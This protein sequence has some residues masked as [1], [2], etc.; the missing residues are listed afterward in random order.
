MRSRQTSRPQPNEAVGAP[1]YAKVGDYL[2]VL[3]AELAGA[4]PSRLP[5]EAALAQRFG[6]GRQTVRRAYGDLVAEGLVKRA[7]GRGS[8]PTRTHR[9]LGS[10][11]SVDDLLTLAHDRLLETVAPLTLI[12][13]SRA[14]MRL[15]L[16]SDD[17]G[18]VAYRL[19]YEG[20][21]Y[22]LT[23]IYLAPFA[24]EALADVIFLRE[25]GASGSETVV[26]LLNQRLEHPI[27]MARQTILAV[28]APPDVAAILGCESKRPLL[29]I[30]YLYF[31][32]ESRP[33]QLNVNYFNPELYEYRAQL[34]RRPES[35]SALWSTSISS[36]VAE[37]SLTLR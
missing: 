9:Y 14:A 33:I 35:P 32:T 5:T 23:R 37:S 10:V 30:E 22:G 2:R 8:Y 15:G 26:A 17:V 13:D 27:A 29:N 19:L 16:P 21:A 18:F 20:D 31:D 36:E 25:P 24:A 11:G 6:V 12:R 1:A 28:S 7:P 4:A 3:I 34:Q